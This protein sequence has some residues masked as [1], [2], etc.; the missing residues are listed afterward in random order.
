M[1]C[2]Y[3]DADRK[4]QSLVVNH[5]Y[6]HDSLDHQGNEGVD[7][8]H[9][10]IAFHTEINSNL[11]SKSVKMERILKVHICGLLFCL[12]TFFY[13]FGRERKQKEHTSDSGK[14]QS[15]KEKQTLH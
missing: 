14:R 13:S 3:L 1:S 5:S 15:M 10:G 4:S 6:S 11:K 8:E 7:S 2:P 9:Q 12:K